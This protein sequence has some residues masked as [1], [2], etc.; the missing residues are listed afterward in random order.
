MPLPITFGTTTNPT[1]QELD[2][3]FATL[4]LT[5]VMPCTIAGTNVLAL[6]PA[7]NAPTISL[8]SQG[9]LFGGILGGSNTGA[10]TA[11][12]ATL[13]P[14]VPVY[15]DTEDGPVALVGGELVA[16]N[17][18]VLAY[19][20]ALNSGGGGFHIVGG[21]PGQFA[22]NGSVATVL[23]SLGPVGS[24]TTVQEWLVIVDAA[25]TKRYIPCF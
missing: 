12:V 2:Q 8:Y 22:V 17:Y 5:G 16:G 13:A 19:D 10:T 1:G 9:Q 21:K 14:A 11:A 18:V 23:G 3:Q 4:A 24:H 6:T 20:S 25:G 7:A 15:N